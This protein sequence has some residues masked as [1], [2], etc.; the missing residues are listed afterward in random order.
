[1]DNIPYILDLE[2][3]KIKAY[4]DG[5]KASIEI[6]NKRID[7]DTLIAKLHELGMSIELYEQMNG[8]QPDE[9]IGLEPQ[10]DDDNDVNLYDY[11]S[12]VRNLFDELKLMG[13]SDQQAFEMTLHFLHHD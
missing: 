3:C 8:R 1:M 4:L 10:N 9:E 5:E 12:M 2:G 6:D 11:S 7:V 13:W